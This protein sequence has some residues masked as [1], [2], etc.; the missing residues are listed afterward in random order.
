MHQLPVTESITRFPCCDSSSSWRFCCRRRRRRRSTP[1]RRGSICASWWHLVRGLRVRRPSSSRARTSRIS[2]SA[3][4]VPVTEQAWDDQTPTGRV[5][6]V[7]LIATIPG[8][9]KNRL[10][11]GGHYDTKKFPVSI[12]RRERRRIERGL[13]DRAR[14]GAQSA[15]ERADHRV[16]VSGRRRSGHRLGGHRSH[17]RQPP[18]RRG[19]EARPGHSRR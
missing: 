1:T 4:G 16:A 17:L 12:R 14:A 8:A 13:P 10:V 18:L 3:I 6:M 9:S 11:I 19:R 2:S 15:P 5:H 7:N